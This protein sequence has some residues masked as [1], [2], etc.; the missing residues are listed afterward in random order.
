MGLH[1]D[2]LREAIRVMSDLLMELEVSQQI[3]AERYERS[4]KRTTQRNG[5][6]ERT[7]ETRVGEIDLHI[8]K[9]R[10]GSYYPS[11]LEPRRRAEQALLAV[12]QQAYIEGVSVRRSMTC[13][14]PW[15]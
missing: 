13:S 9:L 4:D 8:P 3:G 2:F 11:L 14:K 10:Q 12:V 7:W 5:Y 1:P 15:G 6:R